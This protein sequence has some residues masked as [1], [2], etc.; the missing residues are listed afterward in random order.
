VNLAN[1]LTALR[2]LL[3]PISVLFLFW[4]V[5]HQDLIAA[6]LFILAALTDGLDG[7]AARVR[8][9]TTQ[10]G[11]SFDPFADKILISTALVCLAKLHRVQW[12]IVWVIL[13]REILVTALRQ[14]AGRRGQPTGASWLG[15]A[16]TMSQIVAVAAV[17]IWPKAAPLLLLAL[18]LTVVSGLDYLVRWRQV[19]RRANKPTPSAAG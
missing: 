8:K 17:I 3:T 14:L 4:D 1:S 2:I 19:L 11:K 15:K 6:G 13:S 16:K 10:F 5:P 7:W 12:W 18:A 9:Q